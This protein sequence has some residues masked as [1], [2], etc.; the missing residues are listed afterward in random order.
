VFPN[1]LL[2]NA[3]HFTQM[4]FFQLDAADGVARQPVQVKF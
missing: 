2:A 4:E 3:F 1:N